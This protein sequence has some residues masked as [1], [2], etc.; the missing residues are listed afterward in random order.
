MKKSVGSR[1]ATVRRS[2]ALPRRL[3]DDAMGALPPAERANFN[4]LVK[5]ALTQFCARRK[6]A[7]FEAAMARMAA[8][9]ELR[10]ASRRITSEFERAERDGL[11]A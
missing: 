3:V 11:D 5:L 2:V 1:G 4:G 9:P 8:D 7:E 6:Q 10:A